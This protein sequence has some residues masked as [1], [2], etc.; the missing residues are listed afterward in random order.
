M[1]SEGERRTVLGFVDDLVE[2]VRLALVF[3][4]E[5]GILGT[6]QV[7]LLKRCERRRATQFSLRPR[8]AAADNPTGLTSP[9]G[10]LLANIA[11]GRR[12]RHSGRSD[13]SRRTSSSGAGGTAALR[14]QQQRLGAT[15][16]LSCT[17][18]ARA[19]TRSGARR[20]TQRHSEGLHGKAGCAVG[21]RSRCGS[22]AL[23]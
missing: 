10:S 7:L 14:A 18:A 23:K 8:T 1:S 4:L 5:R 12:R 19:H 9:A 21:Q 6:E 13:A 3:C 16:Q 11:S 22:A 20:S 2:R 15:T 17:E